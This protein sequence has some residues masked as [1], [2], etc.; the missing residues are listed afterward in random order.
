MV[1][2]ELV[3]LDLDMSTASPPNDLSIPQRVNGMLAA[4]DSAAS[5]NPSRPSKWL[6][7][8]VAIIDRA[9]LL[10]DLR[11]QPRDSVHFTTFEFKPKWLAPYP[12]SL[13]GTVDRCR[14][15]AKAAMTAAANQNA[16]VGHPFKLCPLDFAGAVDGP[17]P[18]EAVDRIVGYFS[19][20]LPTDD[21]R[22]NFARWLRT[23]DLFTKLRDLQKRYDED[24]VLAVQALNTP[25]KLDDLSVAM[26][27]R[28]CSCFVK[29]PVRGAGAVLAKL[30]DLDRKDGERKLR[31]WAKMQ[32]HL[33]EGGY[34]DSTK[35]PQELP[36]CQ[37]S[38]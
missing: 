35:T 14:E 38:A 3:R 2:I 1:Q 16:G 5:V 27:L 23:T 30:V 28:D 26:T 37:L 9:L 33:V 13:P 18:G 15:C 36:K 6:G 4:F 21:S 34:Y 29:V 31:T 22:I 19:D 8:R 7:S 17:R 32:T 10:E 25:A 20:R 11:L 12:G 24:G